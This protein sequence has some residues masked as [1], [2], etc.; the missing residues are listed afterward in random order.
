MR[1]TVDR[2]GS[3]ESKSHDVEG[4]ARKT[5]LWPRAG[6][7]ARPSRQKDEMSQASR[8]RSLQ[9]CE[10]SKPEGGGYSN[11]A[12]KCFRMSRCV[13][14]H[15]I[16]KSGGASFPLEG[17][18]VSARPWALA[19]MARDGSDRPSSWRAIPTV[20]GQQTWL[21]TCRELGG[22]KTGMPTEHKF[23]CDGKPRLPGDPRE[24]RTRAARTRRNAHRFRRNEPKLY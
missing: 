16:R 10:E 4:G 2:G 3:K 23:S 20:D 6:G 22:Q 8:P 12:R 11:E 24:A 15:T 19:P 9:K 13:D 18:S 5:V 1:K 17:C 21:A 14:I 7:D